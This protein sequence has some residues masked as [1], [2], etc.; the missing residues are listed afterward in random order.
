MSSGSARPGDIAVSA[1]ERRDPYPKR[2]I[3]EVHTVVA[4]DPMVASAAP[5]APP[6]DPAHGRDISARFA[7]F[8]GRHR[9]GIAAVWI[10]LFLVAA[11]FAAT[12]MNV[13]SGGGWTVPGSDSYR[14]A[15][16][17]S[18]AGMLG[19]G[20]LTAAV[21]VTDREYT[22]A[23]PQF[24]ARVR[25]ALEAA[26][27]DPDLPVT[28]SYGWSTLGTLGQ[29][30]FVGADRRTVVDSIAI[31]VDD[32]VT[33]RVLPAVQ[34]RLTD[35][36]RPQGLE[37][38][39]VSEDALFAAVNTYSQRDLLIAE[40]ITL[41]LIA[42]ILL[43]LY[44]SVAAVAA[45]MAV[46][47][48]TVVLTLGVLSPLAH[49]VSLSAFLGNAATMLGLGV[50]VDYSL[51]MI[52]RFQE[53]LQRGRTVDEAVE[54]SL[55]RSGHTVVFSGITVIATATTLFL[56]DLN[57]ITSLAIG[58]VTGVAISVLVS[59]LL[60]PT[61]LHLLGPRINWG[62]PR[63]LKQR[64]LADPDG[65][66]R[67]HRFAMAVM[68]RPVVYCVLGILVMGVLALPALGLRTFFP[69]MRALPQD[70]ATRQGFETIQREF[71]VGVTSPVRV[72][73]TSE[74]SMVA[75]PATLTAVTG[76]VNTL[77]ALPHAERTLSFVT[78]LS[79]VSPDP[80]A[81]ARSY[82]E[83]GLAPDVRQSMQYFL[84]S[85]GRTTVIEIEPDTPASADGARE[86]VEAARTVTGSVAP[87]LTAHVGGET[88]DGIDSNAVIA[89]GLPY[90][91]VAALVDVFILLTIT[92][93]SLLL[94][95]KAIALNLLSLGATYGIVVAVFQYGFGTS[96]L[97]LE[98]AGY[99]QNFVP[100]LT[101][102][103][104]FSLNTDYE[105]FLLN[106]VRE[107]YRRTGKNTAAVAEGIEMT[108]PLISS[109]AVLMVAVF[110][111][112][113]FTGMIPIQQLGFGLALGVLLD[114]T[115]VRLILVPSAMRLM[116]DWNWWFPSLT[117]STSTKTRERTAQ[118][119]G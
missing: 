84:S 7:R 102:A 23:D 26:T 70:S 92:F 91:I 12:I 118:E 66:G 98:H 56:I 99:L 76:L 83:G 48:T 36:F 89:E 51:F 4:N 32:G 47:V 57:I 79:A 49:N 64:P 55:R 93:R 53:E 86:L 20:E 116:G 13:L 81:G 39:I 11:P 88:A 58:A 65:Q 63:F 52:S 41:P 101:L 15:T 108:G 100:V 75:D 29:G 2:T 114:A 96:L 27:S 71:G 6:P 24:Q 60:L 97:G 22:V 119:T 18:E 43:F 38:S 80:S 69:D 8:T 62:R 9:R 30:Q 95:L 103:I 50:G 25:A 54:I 109:A 90:V 104:L 112:F 17:L 35:G 59:T 107:S 68:R 117:R 82:V 14:A 77:S 113:A 74:E 94:P 31:G 37:V 78:L 19:R 110:G 3:R 5:A 73:V 105:V 111:A 45:S 40:M 16:I 115:I 1:T 34:Q 72:V 44:R 28:S 10:A 61:L 42:I 87:G 106:R 67:W 46:G 85:D 33:R 21:V